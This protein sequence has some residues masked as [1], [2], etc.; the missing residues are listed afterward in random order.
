MIRRLAVLGLLLSC[1]RG[2]GGSQPT[3]PSSMLDG[4]TTPTAAGSDGAEPTP[5][6][7]PRSPPPAMAELTPE[8]ACAKFTALAGEGCSWTERFPPEFHQTSNCVASLETWVSP[9]TAEHANLQAIINCW[10]LDC[11]AAASCMVRAQTTP[12]PRPPRNCGRGG[13]A[14]IYVDA[15]PW[16]ARR[17]AAVKRFADV[18]TTVEA[19]IEVC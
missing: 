5:A 16:S 9:S 13:P 17:G 3:I 10:A 18:K 11:D 1:Q 12:P 19:P 8:A 4:K 14:P 2:D 15:N 6:P 7:A